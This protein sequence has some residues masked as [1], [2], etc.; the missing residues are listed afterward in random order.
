MPNKNQPL[1]AWTP[2]VFKTSPIIKQLASVTRYFSQMKNWPTIN[3][4]KKLFEREKIMVKPVAQAKNIMSYEDQYEPRIYLKNELQTRT[5]NWHDFFNALIWL[6][7][8]K[9]KK[10]LNKLHFSQ[11]SISNIKGKR[12]LLENRITQF[13]ECGAIIISSDE[14]LLNLIRQHQWKT[15]FINHRD[16]FDKNIQCIVFGHAIFEKALNPYIGMTC[17]CLLINDKSLLEKMKI[18]TLDNIVAQIW[19]DKISKKP[20]KLQPF[21][22]LGIPGYWPNQDALFYSNTCYFREKKPDSQPFTNE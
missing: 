4:Y 15:L 9:T 16:H 8:P 11:S 22:I 1:T 19:L 3:E 5:E 2:S 7:F 12:S 13:D 21:P 14:K 6:S 10:V 17:H 20:E 18:Q